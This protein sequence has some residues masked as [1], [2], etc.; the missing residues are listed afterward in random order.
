[1]LLFLMNSARSR[2]QFRRRFNLPSVTPPSLPRVPPNLIGTFARPELSLVDSTGI[3]CY[4]MEHYR[5]LPMISMCALSRR[6]WSNFMRMF[7][8][9]PVMLCLLLTVATR[10]LGAGSDELL[11]FDLAAPE[12][13]V[14][15]S[16]RSPR[17]ISKIAE[18]VTVV[19]SEQITKL[20]VASMDVARDQGARHRSDESDLAHPGSHAA[21]AR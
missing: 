14:T 13:Q 21:R 11:S 16:A 17:P 9:V 6:F 3:I 7:C 20:N 4:K 1:M 10:A 5:T 15:A 12:Q 19:T 8:N 2:H 18:N